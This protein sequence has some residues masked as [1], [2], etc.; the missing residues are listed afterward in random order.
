V[1]TPDDLEERVLAGVGRPGHPSESWAP[2][3]TQR[4]EGHGAA[5]C[6]CERYGVREWQGY[7]GVAHTRMA[8]ESAVTLLHSHPFVP[9][10]DLCVVHNGSFSNYASV[11]R[12]MV[13]DGVRFDSDNDSEVAARFLAVGCPVG[14]T[15]KRP[16]VG[17]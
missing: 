12:H 1:A 13:A 17:S 11:R 8:T 14:T 6:T 7:L 3:G 15:S 4:P 2:G 5:Q 16:P 10:R 9:M